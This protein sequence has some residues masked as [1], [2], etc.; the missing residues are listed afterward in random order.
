MN[1]M[2]DALKQKMQSMKG[3]AE[4]GDAAHGLP[5]APPSAPAFSTGEGIDLSKIDPELIKAIV[6]ELQEGSADEA[7][8]S[9]EDEA[10]EKQLGLDPNGVRPGSDQ[11]PSRN[12]EAISA[13]ADGGA[14]HN[15]GGL[16][17]RA[18]AGA[19]GALAN[20]KSKGK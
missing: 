15:Q 14:G 3:P 1:P 20:L 7:M 5:G 16:H 6:K 17:A 12:H 4:A 2:H 13:I 19:K 8:E 11:A 18:A 9:P 10:K